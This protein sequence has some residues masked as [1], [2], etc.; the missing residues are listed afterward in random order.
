MMAPA[1][2][3]RMF[4]VVC[5]VSTLPVIA[6][7]LHDAAKKGNLARTERLIKKG[8]D[9]NAKDAKGASPLHWA[10]FYGHIAVV[11]LLIDKGAGIDAQDPRGTTALQLAARVGQERV[12]EILIN[13]GAKVD[14][15]DHYGGT[16]LF[17]ACFGGHTNVAKFLIAKGA[18]V[19]ARNNSAWTP[20]HIAA[21]HGQVS[22]VKLL[23]DKGAEVNASTD[24]GGTPLHEAA[25]NGHTEVVELLI[26]KGAEVNARDDKGRTPL[27]WAVN[28]GHQA[29][30]NLLRTHGAKQSD[31]SAAGGKVAEN[32][33]ELDGF[34]VAPPTGERWQV[35]RTTHQSA[36]FERSTE[37]G[38]NHTVVAWAT[39]IR[40]TQTVGSPK[41]FLR[42]TMTRHIKEFKVSTRYSN[43]HL[44]VTDT[45][46]F[47]LSCR[48]CSFTVKDHGVPYAPRKTFVLEG[49]ILDCLHPKSPVPLI[50]MLSASQRY[51]QGLQPLGLD[52]ELETF[53][54][55]V[56]VM[57]VPE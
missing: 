35:K 54:E 16:A 25:F 27:D 5:L 28:Q 38:G 18:D 55:G 32:R 31:S 7:P 30:A 13:K 20:L 8:T 49:W 26:D 11:E 44:D 23:I 47:G 48:E 22:L 12:V 2:L 46:K 3:A 42:Q 53:R 10:A 52:T 37:R 4:L 39:I 51:L 36:Y 41:E 17:M 19:K 43:P 1:S 40:G 34:A 45:R 29:V 6:G 57:P 14:A 21:A 9:V 56:V 33:Y 15:R 24:K 50:L